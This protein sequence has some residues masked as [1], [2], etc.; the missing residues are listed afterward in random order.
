MSKS[1]KG[2]LTNHANNLEQ[3]ANAAR[4]IALAENPLDGIAVAW[5]LASAEVHAN[6]RNRARAE[7][8][9]PAQ[10][11]A[12]ISRLLI[13]FSDAVR[14]KMTA[15]SRILSPSERERLAMLG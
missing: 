7:G 4:V 13:E 15:V 10:P 6:L 14:E 5:D 11:P 9:E 2:S 8:R 12:P 1:W 3:H